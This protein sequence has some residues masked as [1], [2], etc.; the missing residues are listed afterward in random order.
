[1][2]RSNIFITLSRGRRLFF[3]IDGS[4]NPESGY[5]VEQFILPL[6]ALNDETKELQLIYEHSDSIKE[7]RTNA[8]YRY[9][10]DLIKKTVRFFEEKYNYKS[11]KFGKGKD[12]TEARYNAYLRS[13]EM[14]KQTV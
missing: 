12:L 2:T 7:L 6:L 8:M 3:V 1:M 4:S 11:D 5:I 9:E 14:D 10:I 13:F